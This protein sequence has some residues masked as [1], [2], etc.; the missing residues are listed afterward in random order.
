MLN[1][2]IEEVH[3]LKTS[4]QSSQSQQS[5]QSQRSQGNRGLSVSLELEGG[6]PQRSRKAQLETMS[7]EQFKQFRVT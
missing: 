1:Y 2:L 3:N 5:Q 4:S 7:D 6:Y